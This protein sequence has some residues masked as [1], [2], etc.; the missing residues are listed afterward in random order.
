MCI[1]VAV[2][3][4]VRGRFRLGTKILPTTVYPDIEKVSP[5]KHVQVLK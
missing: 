1:F 5:K 2:F 4:I 3:L